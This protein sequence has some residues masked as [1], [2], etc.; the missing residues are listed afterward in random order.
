MSSAPAPA[1]GLF[2]EAVSRWH[3][4]DLDGAE[5]ALHELRLRWFPGLG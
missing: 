3:R 5:K 2:H 4:G 1:R